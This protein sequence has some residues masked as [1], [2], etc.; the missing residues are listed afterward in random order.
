MDIWRRMVL[1]MACRRRV[2]VH[3]FHPEL[4]R[5]LSG[6]LRGCHSPR[7]LPEHHEQTT[8]QGADSWAVGAV[9]RHLFS[10]ASRLEGQEGTL[11]CSMMNLRK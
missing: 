10:A 2:D 9:I 6:P 1:G 4:V 7:K 8:G 5:N 11:Y 3:R